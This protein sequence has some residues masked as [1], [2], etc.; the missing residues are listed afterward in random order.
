[1]RFWLT[2]LLGMMIYLFLICL[3]GFMVYWGEPIWAAIITGLIVW[4]QWLA[5]LDRKA[6]KK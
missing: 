3:I 1:M 2:A 4:M 6:D 5:Y